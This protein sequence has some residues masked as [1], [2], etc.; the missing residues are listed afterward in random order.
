MKKIVE[1]GFSVYLSTDIGK[2]ENII[3]KAV[4]SGAEY[5]FTS[6]NISE[7]KIDKQS[8]LEKIIRLCTEKK[9]NL[10]VDIN[11]TTKD[12]IN[13][14]SGNIYLRIDDGLTADEILKLSEKNKI[15]LNASTV[16]EE[17]LKYLE[18]QGIDF[19]NVLSLHN[20]Y[21][22]RFTGISRE[23]LLEQN[24]KYKK[25][26]IKTM[27]F[28]KG[29]ELRKPVYEGLPTVEEHRKMRFLK[30][31]LDL[32][33]LNTDIILIGDIDLS[34]E[35]WKEFG[36]FNK[37]VIPLRNSCDILTD[38]IFKDRT[39]SSEYV[40]R[41]VSDGNIGETRKKFCEYIT[42]ELAKYK[43]DIEKIST[44]N[45]I[46]KGDILVSNSKYMRYEG[47][48]EIALKNLGTDEKRCIISKVIEEDIE[49]LDYI[50]I[51]KKFEFLKNI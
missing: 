9:L 39:D 35:H 19:S 21:P 24:L 14:N 18:K 4:K 46:K 1:T 38:R 27:A 29:D 8:E 50:N 49:L 36:Y 28:V 30:S 2:N 16:T 5:V 11:S 45:P 33:S 43:I 40:V 13:L 32:R 34:C 42:K 25:Y 15:V 31:C 10:I 12:I 47:E 48:L 23:Y 41:A 17:D 20:F 22:K 51:L 44:E 6:L 26:G 7:E 37:G 3:E